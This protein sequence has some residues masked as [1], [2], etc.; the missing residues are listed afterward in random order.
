MEEFKIIVPNTFYT[1]TSE[2]LKQLEDWNSGKYVKSLFGKSFDYKGWRIYVT[3]FVDRF[4]IV[5]VGFK[6]MTMGKF[7]FMDGLHTNNQHN[8]I[9]RFYNSSSFDFV[10]HMDFCGGAL[11]TDVKMISDENDNI[12]IT[13]KDIMD[14]VIKSWKKISD[15][16]QSNM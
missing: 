1:N 16:V 6:G 5:V 15:F 13:L 10:Q 2:G 3:R 14:A 7:E 9:L 11:T 12:T 8:P 4:S